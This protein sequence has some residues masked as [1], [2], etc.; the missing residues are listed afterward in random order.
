MS[1]GSLGGLFFC[2]LSLLPRNADA[3]CKSG[4]KYLKMTFKNQAGDK[5]Y[6]RLT[7]LGFQDEAGVVMDNGCHH[8]GAVSSCDY[9]SSISNDQCGTWKYGA[10]AHNGAYKSDWTAT[11]QLADACSNPNMQHIAGGIFVADPRSPNICRTGIC[12]HAIHVTPELII[13]FPSVVKISAYKMQFLGQSNTLLDVPHSWTLQ[14]S[15]DGTTWFDMDMSHQTVQVGRF[16]CAMPPGNCNTGWLPAVKAAGTDWCAPPTSNV[17]T[18]TNMSTLTTTTTTTT[19]PKVPEE[20]PITA[21]GAASVKFIG[22]IRLKAAWKDDP[23][24]ELMTQAVR[25]TLANQLGV[26]SSAVI[27]VGKVE[28]AELI[29]SFSV[30]VPKEAVEDVE[31]KIK[32][33]KEGTTGLISEV[34]KQLLQVGFPEAEL[35]NVQIESFT[36]KTD[37]KGEKACESKQKDAAMVSEGAKARLPCVFLLGGLIGHVCN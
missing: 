23:N 17:T 7:A 18:T 22:E 27:A 5:E 29:V 20:A 6:F 10:S 19:L 16:V 37:C 34:K 12:F 28:D 2:L 3:G 4:T 15:L 8:T 32:G 11:T 36:A 9:A 26:N 31:K 30:L 21:T 25:Q 35:G 1:F 24:G 33:M 14:G 13:E